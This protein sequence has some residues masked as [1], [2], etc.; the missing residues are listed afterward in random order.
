MKTKSKLYIYRNLNRGGF[1]IKQ[2]GLVINRFDNTNIGIVINPKFQVSEKVSAK[3]KQTKHRQVHAYVVTDTTFETNQAPPAHIASL[4]TLKYNPHIE[5]QFRSSD[6]TDLSEIE[7]VVFYNNNAYLIKLDAAND[8]V[9]WMYKQL[10]ASVTLMTEY[11][12]KA[13]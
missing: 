10:H 5:S 2:N 9:N 12:N 1:S 8:T 4:P 7:A 3:I 13:A 11:L 6:G